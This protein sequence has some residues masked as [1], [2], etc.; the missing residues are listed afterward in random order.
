MSRVWKRVSTLQ[1]HLE[2][3]VSIYAWALLFCPLP[4]THTSIQFTIYYLLRL[5]LQYFLSLYFVQKRSDQSVC[6]GYKNAFHSFIKTIY[7]L[8]ISQHKVSVNTIR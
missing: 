2:L 5:K 7:K 3:F 6:Q 1:L 8:N 4:F